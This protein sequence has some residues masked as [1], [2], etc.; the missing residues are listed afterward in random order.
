MKDKN[1]NY[2]WGGEGLMDKKGKGKDEGYAT[3]TY[4]QS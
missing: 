2:E 4:S 1:G 3:G